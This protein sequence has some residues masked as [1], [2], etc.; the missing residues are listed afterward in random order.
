MICVSS[1]IYIC[2]IWCAIPNCYHRI[3]IVERILLCPNSISCTILSSAPVLL[4]TLGMWHVTHL[5]PNST[6]IFLEGS[7]CV[8]CVYHSTHVYSWAPC[9][10]IFVTRAQC[11]SSLSQP[12]SSSSKAWCD[13]CLLGSNYVYLCVWRRDYML[14]DECWEL[15]YLS[16]VIGI[17]KC[18]I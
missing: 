4:Y 16:Y 11:D 8:M 18:R 5:A 17:R 9:S 7:V 14:L 6:Y 10:L 15:P 1:F 12:S 2:T 13:E 3:Y